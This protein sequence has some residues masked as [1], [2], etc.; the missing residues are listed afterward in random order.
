M[1]APDPD[2]RDRSQETGAAR[3]A[4]GCLVSSLICAHSHEVA[5]LRAQD[6]LRLAEIEDRDRKTSALFKAAVPK[7]VTGPVC[8]LCCLGLLYRHRTMMSVYSCAWAMSG[9]NLR[10]R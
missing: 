10:S 8:G 1:E 7:P 3:T 5:S 4:H 2:H 9:T 6:D